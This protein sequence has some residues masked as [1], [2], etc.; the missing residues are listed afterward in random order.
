MKT[1]WTIAGALAAG[2]ML[3]ACG[4]DDGGST[5]HA[6][7]DS[8]QGSSSAYSAEATPAAPSTGEAGDVL[9]GTP[10]DQ[11]LS[12]ADTTRK[13]IFTADL[14]FNSQDVGRSFT[15]AG[16]LARAN[17]GYVEKSQYSND[18]GDNSKR[19]ASL[20]IR[21]PVQNYESLVASLRT[22]TGVM[23]DTEGS[24][25]SEVNEQY[26][27]LQSRLRNLERTE[28]QYLALLTDAKTIPDILTVQDRLSGVRSQIEQ[29]QGRLKVLDDLT[30]F[31]TI[32]LTLNPL[33]APAS[34]SDGNWSLGD[35]FVTSLAVSFE[36]ARFATA[37][38][39][40]LV[41]AGVWL[42]IPVGLALFGSR[43]FRQRNAPAGEAS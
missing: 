32:N 26:T 10:D 5:Y 13:I 2:L 43:R 1:R 30:D 34:K 16:A 28:Q 33:A 38:A 42:V 9:A 12:A 3:A 24:N 36:A 17:G 23:V 6:P 18:P 40:V 31:A 22:M 4:D 14:T 25:S 7:G 39:I 35:V 27:D 37:A 11:P 15:D 19:S 8:D 21:V 41:V 29:I 20:T